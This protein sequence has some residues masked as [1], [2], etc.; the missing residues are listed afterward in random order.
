MNPVRVSL[1]K[2]TDDGWHK[3]FESS[4]IEKFIAFPFHTND[5]EQHLIPQQPT[6]DV[7]NTLEDSSKLTECAFLLIWFQ[8]IILVACAHSLPF[9]FCIL[10]TNMLTSTICLFSI[11][12]VAWVD[13]KKAWPLPDLAYGISQVSEGLTGGIGGGID[14]GDEIFAN[15]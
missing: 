5:V 1:M 8:L 11:F 9:F 14:G 7:K 2:R 12:L 13:C 3:R 4:E 15:S 6:K 10:F